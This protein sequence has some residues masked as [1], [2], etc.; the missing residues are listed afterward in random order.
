MTI[1][2]LGVLIGFLSAFVGSLVGLGGG[3]V[4]VPA[5]L[6]LFENMEIFSWVTHQAS[7]GISLITKIFTGLSS[8]LKYIILKRVELKTGTIFLI[9]SLPGSLFGYWMNTELDTDAFSL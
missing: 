5:M 1:I 9:G 6:F 4:F 3:I 2:I 7:V 8:T